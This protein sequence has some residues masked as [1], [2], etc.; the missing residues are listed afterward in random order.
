MSSAMNTKWLRAL[1]MAPLFLSTVLIGAG[2]EQPEGPAERAGEN[3]DRAADDIGDALDPAGPAER[4]GE[5][6]D[7][8]ANDAT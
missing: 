5:A 1:G 3:L 8:A 2:C 6:I 4:A 7:D